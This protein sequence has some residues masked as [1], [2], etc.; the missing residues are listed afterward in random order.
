[1][2]E[3]IGPRPSEA[4]S[5]PQENRKY[6]LEGVFWVPLSSCSRS[7]SSALSE[8]RSEELDLG[9]TSDSGETKSGSAKNPR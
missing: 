3:K 1:M 5:S 9:E 2:N 4:I 6:V 8:L 7:T